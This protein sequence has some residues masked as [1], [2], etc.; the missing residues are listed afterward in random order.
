MWYAKRVAVS[1]AVRTEPAKTVKLKEV[2]V[3]PLLGEP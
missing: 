3:F 1:N 2:R